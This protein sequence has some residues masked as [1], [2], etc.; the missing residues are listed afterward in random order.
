MGPE[1]AQKALMM[2]PPLSRTISRGV[3]QAT[4][5]VR[6]DSVEIE[7]GGLHRVDPDNDSG[8]F[9]S[10]EEEEEEAEDDS[11]LDEDSDDL[12]SASPQES[13]SPERSQSPLKRKRSD[14]PDTEDDSDSS[15]AQNT[16]TMVPTRKVVREQDE[17]SSSVEV[18][19]IR[20]EKSSSGKVVNSV[21][22]KIIKYRY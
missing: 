11:D 2:S 5:L 1:E 13:K 19:R 3:Y 9:Y 14:E 20:D 6:G 22:E 4:R 7:T 12:Y 15:A 18:V 17:N 10:D 8:E 16:L 21:A